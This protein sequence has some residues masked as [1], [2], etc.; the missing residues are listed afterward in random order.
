[1]KRI[2]GILMKLII[3]Q[4]IF[5]L[6]FQLVFHKQDSFLEVKR[7]AQY[8]GVYFDNHSVIMDVFNEQIQK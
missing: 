1:M 5:L 4:F 7:L 3:I 6:F 8:E 2:E